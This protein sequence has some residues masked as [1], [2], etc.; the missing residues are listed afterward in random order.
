[1]SEIL[2]SLTAPNLLT[3]MDANFAEEM[4][5]FGRTLPDAELCGDEELLWFFT[6]PVGYNGVLQAHLRSE[7]PHLIHA[8][9]TMIL[10]YFKQRHVNMSWFIGPA[11]RPSNLATYLRMHGLTYKHTSTGMALEIAHTHELATAA[12]LQISEVE[13]DE[14]LRIWRETSR[15]GW[16]STEAAVQAY[17][18]TYLHTGF[19]AGKI[20]HHYIG[21]QHGQPVAVSSLLLHAGLAGIYGIACIPAARRQG[22]G[23]AMTLHALHTAQALGYQVAILSPTEMGQRIYERIGFQE[24][25]HFDFYTWS[26]ESQQVQ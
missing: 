20:W 6:G 24:V 25:C 17:Y 11:T 19:G 9:I 15:Q 23:A 12:H 1:M 18:E 5:C 7:D 21:W 13:N 2:T 16:E 22:I 26:P 8:K 3:A 14:M 4:A 10:D